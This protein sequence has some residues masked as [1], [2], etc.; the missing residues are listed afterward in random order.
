MSVSAH[1]HV[2]TRIPEPIISLTEK[3][4]ITW[5]QI[6]GYQ[7][8]KNY[9]DCT[10][11]TISRVVTLTPMKIHSFP[12]TRL[13]CAHCNPPCPNCEKYVYWSKEYGMCTKCVDC[14]PD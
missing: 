2:A 3:Q 14:L 13:V 5:C 8:M 10:C 4:V 7:L 1:V 12:W 9:K 11:P 6:N